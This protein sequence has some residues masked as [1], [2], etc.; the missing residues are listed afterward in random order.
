MR[1]RFFLLGAALVLG[2]AVAANESDTDVLFEVE[3][4]D[5]DP[6]ALAMGPGA[7]PAEPVSFRIKGRID[8][9]ADVDRF[10]LELRIGDVVGATITD[11]SGLDPTLCLENG[12]G[13]LVIG[14]DET[15]GGAKWGPPPESP[16]PSGEG[17]GSGDGDAAIYTVISA[18]GTY[19]LQAS[20]EDDT[21]GRYRLDIVVARPGLEA[22]P[23]GTRQIVFVD[24]DGEK[25]NMKP[26]ENFGGSGTKTLS[27][28]ADFLPLWG[29]TAADKDE[30]IDAALAMIEEKLSTHVR[31]RGLNGD[32]ATSGVPGEFDIEIRNSRDH[33]DTFGVDPLVTRVVIGGTE[34]EAGLPT[35]AISSGG[36]PGNF[37]TDA[38][39]IVTLNRYTGI[40][41][42]PQN[43]NNFPIA[44]GASKAEFVGRVLG[45]AASHELG[46]C[47][48]CAHTDHTNDVPSLMD[49]GGPHGALFSFVG[50][51]GIF[52]TDD[53]PTDKDLV[54]D[55]HQV[56]TRG[57]APGVFRGTHDTLNT[58]A[59]GL[60]TGHR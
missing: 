17:E 4:N 21:T 27:P 47:F 37:K 11:T 10:E 30:V 45:G 46:H 31:E 40:T 20:G 60:S 12:A 16:L 42:A 6:Q 38:E 19:V 9:A 34:A 29:L 43:L 51:D 49:Q 36:G 56:V 32:F 57:G 55:D 58:V 59:F 48:G 1:N 26:F 5:A 28:L 39:A 24:F 2:M 53:D 14:N 54:V 7:Q 8:T 33:E 52:G 15:F 23:A 50:P 44:P 35:W 18:A 41:P 3:P 13:E 22:H 25:M